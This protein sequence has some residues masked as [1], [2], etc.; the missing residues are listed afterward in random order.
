MDYLSSLADSFGE[1]AEEEVDEE[2]D[3]EPEVA[4]PPFYMPLYQATEAVAVGQLETEEW[5]AIWQQ[6]GVSLESMSDQIQAQVRRVGLTFGKETKIAGE[7]LLHGLESALEALT[8]M[9]EF[10]EDQD[11]EHLNQG[12]GDLMEASHVIARATYE[13]QTLR[14]NIKPE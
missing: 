6:V 12:W 1:V 14:N 11:P 3:S 7:L 2:E 5:M 4:I 8:E 13:F 9:G 10:L